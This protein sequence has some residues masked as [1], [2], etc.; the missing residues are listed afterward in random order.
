LLPALA[1][2]KARAQRINCTSNL[3]QDGVAFKTYALDNQD[4]Y[5]MA[6]ASDQGGPPQQSVIGGVV[7]KGNGSVQAQAHTRTPLP[8]YMYQIFGVM[9]NE[10]STPKIVIC[11]S[12][13]QHVVQSNFFMGV[14]V[15]L[16][17]SQPGVQSATFG[18][19]NISFFVD[20]DANDQYPQ[21]ML[22]G[23]RNIYG[24][25]PGSATLPAN[26]SSL[27]SGYG[28]TS[29]ASYGMGTNFNAGVVTPTFTDKM[30]QKN[31]NILIC[32]GS[33]Q[34][35]SSSRFRDALRVT[36]DTTATGLANGGGGQGTGPNYFMF[37]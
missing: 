30:H 18:N 23:D 31:G 29:C 22:C 25:A 10:L 15:T 20:L 28:N 24:W 26:M 5:P 8:G 16:P 21:M 33:V 12:E 4:S 34:Q 37:P 11:P 7:K 1:R 32:D 9:S 36:G 17:Q 2:A 6:V 27:N 19:Y 35:L 3:K 13:D 14:G